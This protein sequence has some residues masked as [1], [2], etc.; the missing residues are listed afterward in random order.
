[1][2]VPAPAVGA[3]RS[4]NAATMR[5]RLSFI[6]GLDQAQVGPVLRA[7]TLPFQP[8]FG[9]TPFEKLRKLLKVPVR[10]VSSRAEAAPRDARAR[11]RRGRDAA[12]RRPSTGTRRRRGR[13]GGARRR[14]SR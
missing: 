12:A 9:N 11:A 1:M 10:A 5:R 2:T 7:G 4:A 8:N 3:T 6:W 13:R 14:G